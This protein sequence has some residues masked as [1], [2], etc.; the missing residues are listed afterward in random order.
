MTESMTELLRAYSEGDSSAF[1]RLVPLVY[2]HL[3]RIARAQLA[4]RRRNTLD[5]TALVHEA[6]LKLARQP[7]G[8]WIDRDHFYAAS[9]QAMRHILVDAARRRLSQRR[10]GGESPK[11][12]PD[13][14]EVGEEKLAEVIAVHDA[15]ETLRQVDE[16]LC[17]V[18]E[19]RFFAGFS[20]EE[21]AELVG[22]SPRT[23][24]RDWRKARALLADWIGGSNE[25]D[26]TSGA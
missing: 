21:T 5:T 17:R 7:G 14:L 16:E 26:V 1:D 9:A 6:Y 20:V 8:E 12:L 3:R 19:C 15:L 23:V 13:E 18:V 2:D 24:K 25:P 4:R 22:R 11:T 10:G